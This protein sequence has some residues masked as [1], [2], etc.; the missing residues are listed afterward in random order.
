MAHHPWKKDI[1]QSTNRMGE[2][3][4]K[5]GD[6]IKQTKVTKKV[7]DEKEGKEGEQKP[8]QPENDEEVIA[9]STIK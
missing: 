8:V 6:E 9:A 2:T 5:F 1:Q 3:F 7:S 4:K